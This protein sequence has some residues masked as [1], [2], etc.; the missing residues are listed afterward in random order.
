[1]R[2]RG[3][4]ALVTGASSG[5]G[6]AFAEALAKRGMALLLAARSEDRLRTVAD[7]LV[8]RHGGRVVVVPID[9]SERDA[10]RR[11]RDAA[12]ERGF[13]PDLLVNNAGLGA[14]GPFADVPLERQL[15]MVHVNVEAL[16]ALTGLYV[17]RMVA[18]HSGAIIHVASSAAFQPVPYLAVYAATK[19]F[20]VSFSEGLW[21]EARRHGVRVVAVAPGPVADTRFGERAEMG[22]TFADLRS[23]PREQ[24]VAEALRALE[25]GRPTVVPGVANS[26]GARAVRLVPRRL[27]LAV[28]ERMFRRYALRG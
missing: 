6:E 26:L 7:R 21:A 16:V 28:T 15:E 18:R 11:L 17:P 20:V 10:A 5:I 3:G 2:Y 14:S 1:M 4:S 13:E 19:A 27:Q 12:D 9:L 22:P 23:V 25:Q 24:V 8:V